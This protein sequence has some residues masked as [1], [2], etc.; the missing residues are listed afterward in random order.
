MLTRL[1][2]LL[3]EG[4]RR[5][6]W[7]VTVK[8]VTV[9]VTELG[10]AVSSSIEVLALLSINNTFQGY[11]GRHYGPDPIGWLSQFPFLKR[12]RASWPFGLLFSPLSGSSSP[13]LS[14][15]DDDG[16]VPSCRRC[17]SMDNVPLATTNSSAIA[18]DPGLL[19]LPDFLEGAKVWTTNDQV[20]QSHHTAM[21]SHIRVYFSATHHGLL[22]FMLQQV[23]R[24]WE[25][26]GRT[27]AGWDWDWKLIEPPSSVPVSK[28]RHPPQPP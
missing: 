25:E 23:R 20:S 27:R 6:T 10:A 13:H 14:L 9:A 17:Q 24:V 11:G 19:S 18:I 7:K 28:E 1:G 21:G 3:R 12:E 5:R 2:V 4:G 22:H 16:D 26:Q 15:Y 8:N